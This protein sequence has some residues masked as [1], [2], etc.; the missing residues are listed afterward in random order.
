LGF[1]LPA[2]GADHNGDRAG[3]AAEAATNFSHPFSLVVLPFNDYKKGQQQGFRD[4][5]NHL[6]ELL[7]SQSHLFQSVL[8]IDRPTALLEHWVRR[9]PWHVVGTATEARGKRWRLS[10]LGANTYVLDY[11]DHAVLTQAVLRRSWWNTAYKAHRYHDA[12]GA[13]IK[14]LGLRDYS[15]LLHHPFGMEVVTR[16]HYRS[17]VFDAIDNF[18]K[19][20]HF[21]PLSSA[22]RT[23]YEEIGARADAII[24][25]SEPAGRNLFGHS[26]QCTVLPNAVDPD[27]WLQCGTEHTLLTLRQKRGIAIGYVG[28]I[29]ERIDI[30]LVAQTA[31][32]MPDADFHLIGPIVNERL[33]RPLRRFP[34]VQIAGNV[35]Y[36]FLPSILRDLDVCMVPHNV[37]RFEN[38]GDA[39]KLYEYIAAGRPVVTTA[40]LGTERFAPYVSVVSS[41]DEFVAAVRRLQADG[42]ETRYPPELLAPHTWEG[43]FASLVGIV[44][45]SRRARR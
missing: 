6:L 34:N 33:L 1:P 20:P 14:H 37:G 15:V 24:A 10:R 13:A 45:Q 16:L 41:E 29:S 30:A 4:R 35:H 31:A 25:V 3:A 18:L 12:V 23:Q 11:L 22:M 27:F 7:A 42:Y 21:A 28:T 40:I 17:L 2:G 9:T 38:D 39:I 19:I 36:S 44:A 8:I 32:R 43:R 26:R 5:D